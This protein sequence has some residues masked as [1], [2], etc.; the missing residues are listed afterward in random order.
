MLMSDSLGGNAKTLMFVNV[1][2][3]ESNLDESYNSLMYVSVFQ[4]FTTYP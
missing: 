3:A 2:P 4:T 1:S